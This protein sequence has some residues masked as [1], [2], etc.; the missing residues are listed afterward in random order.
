MVLFMMGGSRHDSPFQLYILAFTTQV[1]CQLLN[2]ILLINISELCCQQEQMTRWEKATLIDSYAYICAN[3]LEQLIYFACDVCCCCN[4]CLICRSSR[5]IHTQL[6]KALRSFFYL[7]G[8]NQAM[9]KCQ[10]TPQLMFSAV[11]FHPQHF[12]R[13]AD[14]TDAASDL[15]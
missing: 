4:Y 13:V 11:P 2:V 9:W 6:I 1:E 8:E 15:N 5:N 10:P 12:K 7:K 14:S 3:R